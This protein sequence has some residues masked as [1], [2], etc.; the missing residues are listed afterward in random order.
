[1]Q[2]AQHQRRAPEESRVALHNRYVDVINDEVARQRALID[3]VLNAIVREFGD[4]F[5]SCTTTTWL[6]LHEDAVL[7]ASNYPLP[8]PL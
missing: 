8:S 2:L 7:V 3:E 4:D 6:R 1:M 5:V